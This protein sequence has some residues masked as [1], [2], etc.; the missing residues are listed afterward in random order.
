MDQELE[1]LELSC[2]DSRNVKWYNHLGKPSI[3]IL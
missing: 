3:H 2:T 1:E